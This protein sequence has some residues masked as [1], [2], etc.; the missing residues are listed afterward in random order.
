MCGLCFLLLL[1]VFVTKC[2]KMHC[3]LPYNPYCCSLSSPA[4]L[5][6]YQLFTHCLPIII[7]AMLMSIVFFFVFLFSLYS[8]FFCAC[9]FLIL[10]LLP[11]VCNLMCSLVILYVAFLLL[12]LSYKF[13]YSLLSS[14]CYL[15]YDC[16]IVL[17]WSFVTWHSAITLSEWHIYIYLYMSFC[18]Q[19]IWT[20]DICMCQST[21]KVLM[22]GYKGTVFGWCCHC[23]TTSAVFL[24]YHFES[25]HV[26]HG[27]RSTGWVPASHSCHSKR[28]TE[29]KYKWNWTGKKIA[30]AQRSDKSNQSSNKIL[31]F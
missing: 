17:L 29:T 26:A 31:F 27:A 15:W 1:L 18:T 4:H 30:A 28:S 19:R 22:G 13:V 24:Q 11:L 14:L 8:V 25:S 10:W 3:R 16:G 20:N 23:F 21:L 12:L 6:M 7:C 2:V 9:A 5:Y